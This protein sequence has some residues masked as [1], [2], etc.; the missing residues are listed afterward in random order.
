MTARRRVLVVANDLV[1]ERMAGPGI[2]AFNLALQLAR[3]HDVTLATR[4]EIDLEPG[5]LTPVVVDLA[6]PAV[7]VHHASTYDAVVAQFLPVP[8]ML[9]LAR[10]PVRVVYDMY[11]PVLLEA[12]AQA[13]HGSPTPRGR[14]QTAHDALIQRTAML[15]GNAFCCA[16]ERQRDY[17]LGS[18]A[19]LGRLT[20]AAYTADPTLRSLVDVVPF[21]IDDEPPVRASSPPIR[22][23]FP[24]IGPTSFVAVWGGGI[25]SWLDPQTPVRAIAALADSHPDVHLVFM[26]VRRPNPGVA[27]EGPARR[28]AELARKLGVLDR[29]VH[30]NE[31]W[32]AYRDRGSWL[33]DADVGISAHFADVE[34]HF[35]FRTRILDY[36]WAGLPV[37]TTRGDVLGE[38]VAS[39]S[40]GVTV[41]VGDVGAW[42]AALAAFADD[43]D[44]RGRAAE[45]SRRLGR[46]FIWMETTQALDRLLDEPG[47]AVAVPV[48]ARDARVREL[49]LRGR[50]SLTHRGI[51]GGLVHGADVVR[52]AIARRARRR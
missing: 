23:A 38:L 12:L 49:Y 43:A 21:G 50:I 51:N 37:V 11:D 9:E 25:W 47:S 24:Q 40:A 44:R 42:A 36:L 39:T 48:L 35:A 2:R 8:A 41:D 1:G 33:L 26:G 18:L 15:T 5:P 20:P 10:R 6:D 27:G 28:A 3:H 45:A 30:F 52:G 7:V 17:L 13:A 46:N 34:T 4:V 14:L 22:D 32:V 29:T 16:S 19:A 31:G